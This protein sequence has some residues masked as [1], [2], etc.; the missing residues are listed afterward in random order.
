MSRLDSGSLTAWHRPTVDILIQVQL[1]SSGS[2]I[3]LLKSLLAAD[4]DGLKA[5]RLTIDL[6]AEID[7][8]L[9]QFLT[10]M[11]W[12]PGGDTVTRRGTLKLHRRIST[13]R[14][15]TEAS[16]LRF[17]ESFYPANSGDS[18]SLIHI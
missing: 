12:P 18:L 14:P 4:Y 9:D 10:Y 11:D 16:T 6:P 8:F 2:L 7:G 3:R 15:S 5:P 17:L 13:H 1:G